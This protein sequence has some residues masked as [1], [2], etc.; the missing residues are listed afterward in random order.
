LPRKGQVRGFGPIGMLESWNI[1]VMGSGIFHHSRWLSTSMTTK[2]LI[3]PEICRNSETLNYCK[4]T[5]KGCKYEKDSRIPANQRY[6]KS[7]GVVY[8]I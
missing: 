8:S 7:G 5:T 4:P 3:F 6:H 1:G 2:N